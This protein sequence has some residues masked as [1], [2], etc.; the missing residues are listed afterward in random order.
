MPQLIVQILHLRETY[1]VWFQN[2]GEDLPTSHHHFVPSQSL[3]PVLV[4]KNKYT[5]AQRKR[6]I[7]TNAINV[8]HSVND[9]I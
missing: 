7:P 2:S 8:T 5:L 3:W 1:G 9:Q 6:Y 4:R